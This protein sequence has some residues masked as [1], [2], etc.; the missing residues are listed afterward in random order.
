MCPS[1][2]ASIEFLYMF[3]SSLLEGLHIWNE[4]NIL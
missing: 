3:M 1:L 2:D 4:E